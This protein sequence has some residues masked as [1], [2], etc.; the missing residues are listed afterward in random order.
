M[1]YVLILKENLQI[2]ET[3]AG[4]RPLSVAWYSEN[5]VT[6]KM[7]AGRLKKLKNT[8]REKGYNPAAILTT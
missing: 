6:F 2:I 4:K 8:L 1:F 7:S 3:L 5:T